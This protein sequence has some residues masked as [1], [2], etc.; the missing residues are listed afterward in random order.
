MIKQLVERRAG[1]GRRQSRAHHLQRSRSQ[2]R[3]QPDSQ[4][5][6]AHRRSRH[7]HRA[8][9]LDS[10][11]RAAACARFRAVHARRDAGAGGCHARHGARRADHRCPAGRVH[12]ALHAPLQHAALRHR[13]D[14]PRRQSQATRDRSWPPGQACAAGGLAHRGRIRLFDARR[15]RDHR[16]ERLE[17][18]GFGVRRLSGADGCRRADEGARRGHRHGADQGRQPL[19]GAVG[20]SGRRGSSGRHGFQ[21]RRHRA[22]RHR[23]A[24]GHQDPGHHQGDHAGRAE[25]GAGRPPAYPVA[26]EAGAAKARA[27]RFPLTRRA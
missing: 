17:L 3:A 25:P 15:V 12:R 21:G 24:D 10:H 18:D 6:T 27:R 7:A 11:R 26:D 4:R 2:D 9:D 22:G 1:A 16:I 20:H 23:A 19:R 14:R 13:R 8:S 5:R